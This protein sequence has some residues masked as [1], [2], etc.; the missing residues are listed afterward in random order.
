ME[1]DQMA[2]DLPLKLDDFHSFSIAMSKK[3]LSMF[4]SHLSRLMKGIQL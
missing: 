3:T 4:K 2:D 1:D